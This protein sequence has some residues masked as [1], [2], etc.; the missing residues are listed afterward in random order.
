MKRNIKEKT[1][2]RTAV[3]TGM[4][5]AAVMLMGCS[6]RNIQG[7][8]G[9]QNTS[10]GT[11]D[12]VISSYDTDVT[13]GVSENT[14]DSIVNKDVFSYEASD[15][16]G[17]YGEDN[18]VSEYDLI[19][20][21]YALT[22]NAS[23][24]V[25]E[26][27]DML[28]GI[29]FEDINFAADGGLYAEMVQNRSFEFTK[30]ASDDE[31]HAWST[32]GEAEAH[33]VTDDPKGALN[34]NNPN[35]LV[36][37][38]RSDAPAGAANAGFLDGI[39]LT[40][41]AEY[42]FSIYARG[43][44][45]YSG[46][47]RVYFTQYG[48]LIEGTEQ[49]IEGI[50]DTWERYEVKMTSPVSVFNNV[51]LAVTIDRGAA[52]FDMVSL[53][54]TDTYKGRRNGLRRDLAEKLEALSPKFLRFPGGCVIE[55]MSLKL[56]YDWKDSIGVDENGEPLLFNG[57][58]GD[59]AARKMGQNIWTNENL[60]N[61]KYPSFMSYGLGFYE[62]FLLAEDIGAVGVP[63]VN[64]GISCLGQ[65]NG[66]TAKIGSLQFDKYV[67][68]ALDLVEFC[69]GGSDTKWGAVRI[70]MGHAEPFALKYIGIGNEQ[71]GSGFYSH[72]EAFVE[73]FD[74]AA[75]KRPELF[76]GIEL[77]YSAGLDD[78]DSGNHYMAAY[79]E[80]EKW[81]NTHQGS[82]IEDFAG[83]IDHHY[84]NASEWFLTHNDYYDE[85][86]YSRTAENMTKAQFGGGIPAFVG[87][88]AAKSNTWRAALAEASYMTGLERNGDIVV[89]AAY[90]PLFGNTVATHWAPDLIWFN[91]HT[92]TCSVNYYVQ[93]IFAEN[94]GTK[95]LE[96]KLE[97][98]ES[99][100]SG[101]K[102][103]IGVG[104]WETSAKFDDIVVTD[105]VTGEVLASCDFSGGN[106]FISKWRKV[107]D[108]RWDV[109]DGVL[110]QSSASTDTA[111]YSS[112]GTA[113]YFG[114]KEWTNY[115]LTL[116][117]VKTGGKEGF[118]IPFAVQDEKNNWFWNIGGWSNTVSSLQHVVGGTKTDQIRGTVKNCALKTNHAY[119]IKI[120]VNEQNVQCYL[121]GKLYVDY[122][123][124]ETSAYETYHVVSTDETGDV[125]IKLVN[126]QDTS[127]TCAV[128][129]RNIAAGLSGGTK[130]HVDQAAAS[131]LTAD[132]V[133]GKKE[134]VTESSF[135]LTVPGSRFNVT[136]PKYSVTVIRIPG[137]R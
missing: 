82:T 45:G 113:A 85:K 124:N 92:S 90:A 48:N 66:E 21:N 2:F 119:E 41:G 129:I 26:I 5:I 95:L 93:K 79:E 76:E 61:D 121:D 103:M 58:Y 131:S 80:A 16:S 27:S 86:N 10:A 42:L 130:A 84:Y 31:M 71:F 100:S 110:V 94:A 89:M 116:T 126:V 114:D 132:N 137:M 133:L 102:G 73:A 34:I 106:D 32:V 63:V 36:V 30:L 98:S 120:V 46:P 60:T 55:G 108:G 104:T 122:D 62:Y 37:E 54:P 33:V 59:V 65:S 127:K 135:E 99:K 128:D 43:I 12:A 6:D 24:E 88:Y 105:N 83:A 112:T 91:N 29:F 75:Q 15:H 14:Q 67:Q 23:N 125:I 13:A 28:F 47:I 20:T 38:N 7:E 123:I 109:N 64:C 117:A 39:A 107:S 111:R 3:I 22:I 96:S 51:K 72:Y 44:E 57:T 87:E 134:V 81:L 53:F 69:R 68:D 11:A 52:A 1:G 78:G 118:L 19:N 49:I 17:I 18:T 8:Q 101:L 115:T 77:I 74:N 25:H 40:E 9:T 56:A 4:L 70:A 35:Y 97:G 136:V 50:T